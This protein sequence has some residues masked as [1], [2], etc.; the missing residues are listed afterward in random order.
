[1]KQLISLT[2]TVIGLSAFILG[3]WHTVSKESFDT[4]D[5]I[6]VGVLSLSLS[7]SLRDLSNG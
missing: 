3:L 1:M 4:I 6:L 5:Y 2:L 7:A